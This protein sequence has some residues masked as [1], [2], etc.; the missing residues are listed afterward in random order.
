LY[1]PATPD[2]VFSD[3]FEGRFPGKGR[4]LFDAQKKVSRIPLI[5]ASYWNATWDFTLYSEGMMSIMDQDSVKLISLTDMC[6]KMP[7][8]P[9]YQG[10]KDFV[11]GGMK[12]VHRRITPVQLADS[13]DS[14][15]KSAIKEIESISA[16]TNINLL[17]EV[18]DIKVWANLGMYFS[19][20]LKSA[21]DYQQ[22][23]NSGD[24]KYLKLSINWLEK[25]TV[26]WHQ[27]VEITTP[28]YKI[29]PLVHYEKSKDKLF[30]WSKVEK[31]VNAELVWLKG[32]SL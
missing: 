27:V 6:R 9:A 29:M 7:M 32:Q 14:F 5:V 4:Q 3:A 15:C 25:A 18:S 17:Y 28:L 10:I 31:E 8:S 2:A 21:I 24:Q 12:S 20:K 26:H 23:V 13:I 16:G 19:N 30:H 1:N 22:Y 11:A